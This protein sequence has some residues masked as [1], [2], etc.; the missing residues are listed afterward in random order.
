MQSD[1]IVNASTISR[2]SACELSDEPQECCAH[3]VDL[4]ILVEL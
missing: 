4:A 3:S 2:F 1:T